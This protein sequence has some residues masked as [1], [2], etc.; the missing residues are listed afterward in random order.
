MKD[1]L[2]PFLNT[3]PMVKIIAFKEELVSILLVFIYPIFKT[4]KIYQTHE[5]S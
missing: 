5:I 1:G 4:W 3:K 2:F